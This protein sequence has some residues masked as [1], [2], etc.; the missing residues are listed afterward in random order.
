MSNSLIWLEQ[1]QNGQFV[2]HV[3]AKGAPIHAAIS[4]ADADGDGDTD[5]IAGCFDPNT[6]APALH[7]YRNLLFTP[8]PD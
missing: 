6:P 3:L 2:E 4:L 7:I 5:V 1:Q 8:Q